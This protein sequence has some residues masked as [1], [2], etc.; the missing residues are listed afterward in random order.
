MIIMIHI[1]MHKNMNMMMM[2]YTSVG[3]WLKY[4]VRTTLMY[5][6]KS[7]APN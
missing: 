7:T 3:F 4:G 6:P 5:A 1:T 2:Q